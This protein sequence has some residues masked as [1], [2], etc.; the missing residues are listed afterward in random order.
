MIY[1]NFILELKVMVPI[2]VYFKLRDLQMERYMPL[3]K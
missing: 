1:T 2:V 3:R